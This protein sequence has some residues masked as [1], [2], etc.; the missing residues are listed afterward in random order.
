[1]V[2]AQHTVAGYYGWASIASSSDGSHLA[3]CVVGSSAVVTFSPRRTV[4]TPG[5]ISQRPDGGVGKLL[6]P[7]LMAAASPHVIVSLAIFTPRLTA[8]P[9]GLPVPP[10]DLGAGSQSLP[11]RME[12]TSVRA[13][14]LELSGFRPREVPHGPIKQRPECGIGV[15]SR[16]P[17]MEA[18]G[19][20]VLV[21]SRELPVAIFPTGNSL[22]LGK[23]MRIPRCCS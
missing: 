1:M 2:R 9:L 13:L 12:V 11:P 4:E 18:I 23:E 5:R 7:H 21:E 10:P 3:A 20:H 8:V 17:T 19:R 22:R 6:P 16:L 14:R 15:V